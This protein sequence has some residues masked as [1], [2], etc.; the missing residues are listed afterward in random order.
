MGVGSPVTR[1]TVVSP[2]TASTCAVPVLQRA[3]E[4]QVGERHLDVLCTA[5]PAHLASAVLGLYPRSAIH[6]R[7][8]SVSWM[9]TPAR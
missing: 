3:E 6:A 1:S 5:C 7:A 4:H 8:A 9:E 2:S